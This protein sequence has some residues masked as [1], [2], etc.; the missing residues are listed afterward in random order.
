M[1]A[2]EDTAATGL[3][4]QVGLGNAVSLNM[5]NMVGIGP[6]VTIPL[7]V[8]ALPGAQSL[9]A[10]V[11]GAAI[12]V[13]DGMVWAELGAMLPEAGGPYAFLREI[14]G[15]RSGGRMASFLYAWQMCF[16][17]PLSVAS[18]CIG[19]AQYAAY[20]WPRLQGNVAA[21]GVLSSLPWT[22][23][24]AAGTC[25][26][27]IVLLYRKVRTVAKMAWVLWGGML[28]TIGTVIVAGLTHFHADLA[29]GR[30]ASAAWTPSA[31]VWSGLA[32]ATL[33]TTYDYWGYYNVCFMGGEVKRPGK[34]IPRAVLISIAV[35]TVL[36][37]LMN[38]AVLGVMP[39]QE[40]RAASVGT[41]KL[42]VVAVMLERTLGATAGRG[43]AAMVLWTAFASVF[44]LLLAFSRVPYVA[45]LDGNFFR[46]FGRLHPKHGFPHVALLGMGAA[47]A[48]FCFFD[49][50]H[51]IAALVTLRILLQFVLL[52]VG[53]VLLRQREPN[54][55][56]PFRMRLYPLPPL[57]ALAGFLFIIFERPEWQ[58]E[59][60][61]G[62]ALGGAGIVVYL[63]RA[64]KLREWPFA[65]AV[66]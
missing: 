7:V 64:A 40:L 33:I 14:Y 58:R 52:Q 65:R 31:G 25:V 35:I 51:V 18:G 46:A 13:C 47:A 63:L 37:L 3:K 1:A 36:Y 59:V 48:V 19:L 5:L 66:D 57:L 53:V 34:T 4:R 27:V 11:L 45:A 50:G 44:A 12:A 24:V 6:F 28:A 43:F 29:F 55:V 9:L 49:I 62:V 22:K 32:A 39:W 60:L 23:P 17:A 20:L 41:G 16:T 10:W 54:R 42:A 56:R 21:T 15:P 2:G 61:Y 8:A 38:V 30:G 26:L